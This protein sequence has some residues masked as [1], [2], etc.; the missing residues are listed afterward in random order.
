MRCFLITAL[1]L[2]SLTIVAQDNAQTEALY[3]RMAK[4]QEYAARGFRPLDCFAGQ[5]RVRGKRLS[6]KSVTVFRPNAEMKCCGEKITSGRTDAHGHFV[7]EP[8]PEGEYFAQFTSKSDRYTVSFAVIRGYQRCDGTHIEINFSAANECSLQ[9][10]AG[11]DYD[12]RDCSEHDAA[13]YRK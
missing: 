1:L 6:R 4:A 12:E 7:I 13:C 9:T 11:V 8:L 5:V 2:S 3:P 10:Y